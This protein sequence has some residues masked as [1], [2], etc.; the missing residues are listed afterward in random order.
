MWY[1]Y[2]ISEGA[3]NPIDE[4]E[5]LVTPLSTHKDIL[6][7]SIGVTIFAVLM[8]VFS[9]AA[10]SRARLAAALFAEAGKVVADIPFLMI[11]AF[12]MY[13]A[14]LGI[15]AIWILSVAFLATSGKVYFHYIVQWRPS[16]RTKF[17]PIFRI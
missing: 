4:L 10:I 2:A 12:W 3:T 16:I 6:Y 9:I 1:S 14:L 7:F 8:I 17:W 15:W 5:E 11:Q 13:F